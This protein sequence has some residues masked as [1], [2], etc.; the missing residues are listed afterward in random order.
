[1]QEPVN[2]MRVKSFSEINNQYETMCEE[3]MKRIQSKKSS[4]KVTNDDMIIP[5]FSEEALLLKWNYNLQQLKCISKH[6]KLKVTGNKQQLMVRIYTFLH[7][8]GFAI[9]LQRVY[10]GHLQRRFNFLRGPGWKDKNVCTN[11]TDFLTMDF[12]S[13]LPHDQFFSYKDED[14]FIYGF[15]TISMSNLIYKSNAKN[16]YNRND[17]PQRVIQD[18]RHLLRIGKILKCPIL[19]QMKAYE[20]SLSESKNLELK[21]VDVFQKMDALG[22]YTNPK[23]FI[24]L[25]SFQIFRFI[26]FL[27]DIWQ[28]RAHLTEEMKR[29][30][31]PPYGFP[32]ERFDFPND[33]S[34]MRKTSLSVIEK[35]V[36][37]ANDKDNQCL[38]AY[39][40][41]GALTL[42]SDDAANAMPHLYH[43]FH[44]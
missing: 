23:W 29:N 17:I 24:E 38:G 7:L 26:R 39:Y 28:Y 42:V 8:S 35:M 12:L 9:T 16:P 30:I 15:D 11:S 32:F 10:R 27:L 1:M 2:L 43:A 19:T 31:C 20:E 22:N 34:F 18:F 13:E 36:T 3:K 21:I 25:S 37:S 4:K 14:N 44:L 6:H 33:L 40:V 41:L 5:Q